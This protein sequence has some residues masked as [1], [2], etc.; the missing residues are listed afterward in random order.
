MRTIVILAMLAVLVACAPQEGKT[1]ELEPFVGGQQGIQLQF[2][3]LRDAVFDGGNDPFDVVVQLT[4]RGEY[5][6]AMDDAIVTL[7]GIRAQEFNK[8]EDDLRK[9]PPDEVLGMMTDPQGNVIPGSPVFV[10]FTGLNH[11]SSITGAQIQFPL[12]A[13]VCYA[14]GTTAV[15]KLCVRKNL[16]SPSPGGICQVSE[17]KPVFNSGSPV[18]VENLRETPQGSDKIRFSFDIA[19]KGSGNVF[20]PGSECEI[21]RKKNKLKVRVDTGMPGLSCTGLQTAAGTAV[22]GT[23][24]LFDG[25]KT[26]SCTQS[27][28]SPSD[29][30]QQIEIG[31]LYVYETSQ[32]T[33]LVVKHAE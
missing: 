5:D 6:V 20:E 28:Q 27:M 11:I 17:A 26:V 33:Q 8:K 13:D 32:T 19:H 12:R 30:E 4:N 2:V 7:S 22:E 29:F 9:H 25:I 21:N 15:S 23:V 24:T 10:E 18:H 31:L 1:V 14:Y 16:V 3:D